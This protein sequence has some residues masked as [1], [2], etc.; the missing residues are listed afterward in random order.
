MRELAAS[1]MILIIMCASYLLSAAL[2]TWARVAG[3]TVP[4]WK[5]GA[6]AGTGIVG[7]CLMPWL[8]QSRPMISIAM[9][10]VLVPWMG[11]AFS[12]DARSGH[13]IVA[14]V[15]LAG[16]GATIYALWLIRH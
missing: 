8:S 15:D 14:I 7:L 9:L 1:R 16:L 2:L 5:I 3:Q 6:W 13:W 12:E 11:F 10:V 4:G